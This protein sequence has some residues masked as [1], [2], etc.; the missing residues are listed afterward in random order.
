MHIFIFDDVEHRRRKR[1]LKARKR[2]LNRPWIHL[3]QRMYVVYEWYRR[4][5]RYI[6]MNVVR[7][8]ERQRQEGRFHELFQ[9]VEGLLKILF[10]IGIYLML[11]A[12]L[13]FWLSDILPS[14]N[15]II[16]TKN[17]IL[18]FFLLFFWGGGF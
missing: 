16:L 4:C 15:T 9:R 5:R 13:W 12:A 11:G 2:R 18:D 6:T 3:P 14:A 10:T 17:L 8:S 1:K 7:Q